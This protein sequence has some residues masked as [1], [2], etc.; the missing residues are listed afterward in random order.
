M[1]RKWPPS[2]RHRLFIRIFNVAFRKRTTNSSKKFIEKTFSSMRKIFS[3]LYIR[4]LYT[5]RILVGS[6]LQGGFFFHFS[7][8]ST[9][10]FDRIGFFPPVKNCPFAWY[11]LHR[12]SR[13][14]IVFYKTTKKKKKTITR[15]CVYGV[16]N[17]FFRKTKKKQKGYDEKNVQNKSCV[18]ALDVV[19]LPPTGAFSN[20]IRRQNDNKHLTI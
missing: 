6:F 5:F 10:W 3:S 18:Y 1:R 15:T 8:C 11:L 13:V 2:V 16:W 12:S 4:I 20:K 14:R 9:E 17:I 19:D 7:W